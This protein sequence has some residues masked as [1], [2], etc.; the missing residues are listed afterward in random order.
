ML[1]GA[2]EGQGVFPEEQYL[3]HNMDFG[4]NLDFFLPSISPPSAACHP[5]GVCHFLG[6]S[7]QIGFVC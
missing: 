4:K 6:I 5:S 1:L 3:E 2:L 7:S